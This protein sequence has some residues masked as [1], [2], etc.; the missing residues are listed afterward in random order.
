[1]LRRTFSTSVL[2][3]LLAAPLIA[4]NTPSVD[5]ATRARGAERVVVAS[6]LRVQPSYQR[7]EFGDELIVSN[8]TLRVRE[9]LKGDAAP[10]ETLSIDVEGG[11]VGEITL[12]VSDMPSLA[13]GEEAVFFMKRNARGRQE[14]HLRG[15]GILKLDSN[16]RVRGSNVTLD[17]VRRVVRGR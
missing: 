1:M 8:A 2:V 10:G 15:Q 13:A 6:V 7:N 17:D 14:P 11:T 4:D 16:D 3:C 12:R 9:V 5:L